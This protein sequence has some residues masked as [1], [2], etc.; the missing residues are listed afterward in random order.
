MDTFFVGA[1]RAKEEEK[2]NMIVM[3]HK[4]KYRNKAT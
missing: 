1:G 3:G 4:I 2:G